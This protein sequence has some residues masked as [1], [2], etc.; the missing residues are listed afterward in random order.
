[1]ILPELNA[2]NTITANMLSFVD[3][4]TKSREPRE[5][6]NNNMIYNKNIFMIQTQHE[7]SDVQFFMFRV[8]MRKDPKK[9][10]HVF[11]V[12]KGTVYVVKGPSLRRLTHLRKVIVLESR[13][14]A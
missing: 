7:K 12:R 9:Y 1:M 4:G 11:N 5:N 13:K 14:D 8:F 3:Q 10:K 6:N 2:C